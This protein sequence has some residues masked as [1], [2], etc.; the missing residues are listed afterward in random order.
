VFQATTPAEAVE[1]AV[2]VQ[3]QQSRRV[4]G[5]SSRG[6]GCGALKA[7]GREVEMVDKGV[8]E[9]DGMLWGHVVVEP[10]WKQDL[11]VAIHAVEKAHA[12]TT[13]QKSKEVSRGS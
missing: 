3:R 11:F 7:E 13:L 2:Y 6:S 8:E 1:I 12:G 10:L 9:T 4:G 5:R